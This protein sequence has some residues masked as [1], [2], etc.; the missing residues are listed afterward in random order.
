MKLSQ[1]NFKVTLYKRL[2]DEPGLVVSHVEEVADQVSA[3][4][5]LRKEGF[6]LSNKQSVFSAWKKGTEIAHISFTH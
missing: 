1:K 5:Y 2:P 3:I 4:T 6:T